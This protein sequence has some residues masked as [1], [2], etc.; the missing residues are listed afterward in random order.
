MSFITDKLKQAIQ[1]GNEDEAKRLLNAEGFIWVPHRSGTN[2]TV[3][4]HDSPD[5]RFMTWDEWETEAVKLGW[6]KG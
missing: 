1:D 4:T 5:E 6:K 2:V 3:F